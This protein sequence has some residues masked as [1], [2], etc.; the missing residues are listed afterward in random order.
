MSCFYSRAVIPKSRHRWRIEVVETIVPS[1]FATTRIA[2]LQ[3]GLGTETS[4]S[5]SEKSI[6]FEIHTAKTLIWPLIFHFSVVIIALLHRRQFPSCPKSALPNITKPS[7]PHFPKV[8]QSHPSRKSQIPKINS[9][10]PPRSSIMT[11][12]PGLPSPLISTT[13]RNPALFVPCGLAVG[14]KAGCQR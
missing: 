14:C 6:V 13:C 7:D 12:P 11:V 4:K 3:N 9:H 2:K 1:Y 10:H 8:H 5:Y